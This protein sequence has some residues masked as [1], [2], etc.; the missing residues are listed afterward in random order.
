MRRSR[1]TRP[2][3]SRVASPRSCSARN[4]FCLILMGHCSAPRYTPQP[5]VAMSRPTT[6]RNGNVRGDCSGRA[7]DAAGAQDFMH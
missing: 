7:S 2:A 1:G 5:I 3:G 6:L 4:P